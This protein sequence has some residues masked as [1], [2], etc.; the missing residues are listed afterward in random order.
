MF[1]SEDHESALE[2]QKP[3]TVCITTLCSEKGVAYGASLYHRIAMTREM[4]A[5]CTWRK[6]KQN[7]YNLYKHEMEF[8]FIETELGEHSSFVG[9]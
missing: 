6:D 8:T 2:R 4:H 7:L 1:Q 9:S 5:L 3:C